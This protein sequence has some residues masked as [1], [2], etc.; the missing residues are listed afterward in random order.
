MNAMYMK[1]N[2][3]LLNI[4]CGVKCLVLGTHRPC[5]LKLKDVIC[6]DFRKF[7]ISISIEY[8]LYINA[9][10]KFTC[11]NNS[12]VEIQACSF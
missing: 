9:T 10:S 2:I 11:M 7:I 5:C 12:N 6:G 4:K 3:I 1:Y 8:A